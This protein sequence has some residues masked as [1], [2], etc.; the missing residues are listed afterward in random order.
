MV[1]IITVFFFMEAKVELSLQRPTSQYASYSILK[2]KLQCTMYEEEDYGVW[3][4]MWKYTV[5][6]QW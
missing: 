6:M 5:S 2:K 1:C 4:V 3:V